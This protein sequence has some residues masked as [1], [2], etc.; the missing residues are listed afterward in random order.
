MNKEIVPIFYACDDNFVKYT[1]VS[2]KSMIENASKGH[3][4]HIY[5]LNTG[6][7]KRMQDFVYSLQNEDFTIEFVDVKDYLISINDKLPLR[8]YYSKTTYYRLFISEMYKEFDKAIYIDSDTVVLQDIYNLYAIDLKDNY[9]GACHEQAMV[10]VDTYGLYV[11]EVVGVNRHKFF[12][13]GLLLINCD[14]FRKNKVLDQ[15][16][17]LLHVYNFVVTQDEDYLNVICKDKVLFIDQGWNVEVFGNLPVEDKDVKIFHYI[18]VAKPWHFHDCRK[19]EYFWKYAE[20]TPVYDE[21]VEVLNNYTDEQR[22][23]D[24]ES[25]DRLLQTAINE[26]AR[27]DSYYKMLKKK[28]NL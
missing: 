18:M 3:N 6:I 4:Y 23:S 13:A 1:I 2:I 27:E 11:E 15:F 14:Q 10:Q 5:I 12:N 28:V 20:M 19:K 26:T 9:V 22:K 7:S 21:I 8:D 25:G 16:I 24:I 17:D